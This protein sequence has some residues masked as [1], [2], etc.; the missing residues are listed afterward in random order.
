MTAWDGNRELRI[1]W[2]DAYDGTNYVG[3]AGGSL[4]QDVPTT[5]GVTY[6]LTFEAATW[7]YPQT[8]FTVSL[9]LDARIFATGTYPV[10]VMPAHWEPFSALFTADAPVTT[11]EFKTVGRESVL[12]DNVQISVV[13]EPDALVLLLAAGGLLGRHFRKAKLANG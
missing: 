3:L 9:N 5:P 11:I 10:V 4:W 2:P 1:H 12:V 8:T 7:G 6:Y 13:P